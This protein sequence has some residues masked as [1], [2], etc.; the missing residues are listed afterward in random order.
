MLTFDTYDISIGAQEHYSPDVEQSY[1]DTCAIKS[2]SLIL[3]ARGIDVT[4]DELRRVAE[5]H[6]WYTPGHGTDVAHLGDLLNFYGLDAELHYGGTI[7][8]LMNL[9]S[10]GVQPMLALDSGELWNPGFAERMEDILLGENPDHALIFNGGEIDPLSGDFH[11]ILTDPGTGDL[12]TDQ[13][14]SEQFLDAW[15]DSGFLYVA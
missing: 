9:T 5:L 12:L 10:Q 11:V 1:S 7:Q 6:G 8:D 4:E 3:H 15:A 2:A 14:G 13:Y